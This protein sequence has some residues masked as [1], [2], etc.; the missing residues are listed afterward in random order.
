V[1]HAFF[2][3]TTFAVALSLA[4]PILLAATGECLSE[5]SG[6]L[7]IG[8]EGTMLTAA[9]AGAAGSYATHSVLV[10]L[11]LAVLAAV[12]VLA[13][14][15]VA[16][17]TVGADQVVSGV[18]I[19][20]FA[21]GGTTFLSRL[22]LANT[23]Q[24]PRMG[25]FHV[26]GLSRIPFLGPVLFS[27][28]PLTYLA[29]VVPLAL[30]FVVARS[31][32]G[33]RIRAI[34]DEPAAAESVGIDVHVLRYASLLTAAALMGL[35]GAFLSI[36]A[37]DGFIENMTEGVGFIALAA[38]VSGNWRPIPVAAV[39]L[40]F[41]YVESLQAQLQT[42]TQAVP[43]ELF[44]ALPYLVTVFVVVVA[45]RRG[46]MPA[47]LARAYK[48]RAVRLFARRVRLPSRGL[49]AESGAGA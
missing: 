40:L 17:I 18:A 1:V 31:Q 43:N 16:T 45:V 37:F 11:L 8:I 35:G 19:N 9:F 47:A 27:Q 38:V 6:V 4:T 14:H 41:G 46:R 7:N 12:I 21:L 30:W 29:L 5:L 33:V 36:A 3:A 25:V 22:L 49:R 20:V 24:V 13:A 34:G 15:G 39:A 23:P 42:V 10:G 26:P 44:L 32:L 48:P 28:R 2:S